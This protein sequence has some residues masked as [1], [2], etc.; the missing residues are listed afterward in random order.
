MSLPNGA[1]GLPPS[2][3]MANKTRRIPGESTAN[4]RVRNF[5][6]GA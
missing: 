3:T 1:P 2:L 6:S 5:E 4:R